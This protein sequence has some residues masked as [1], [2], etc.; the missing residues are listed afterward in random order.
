MTHSIL[1]ISNA[2][3]RLDVPLPVSEIH[4]LCCGLLCSL[5]SA[6]AKTR[7][8]TEILDAA[9]LSPEAVSGKAVELKTLDAWFSETLSS[10]NGADL[11]FSPMLP[12]DDTPASLR[13]RAL[14]E[15]CGGFTYGIGIALGQRGQKPL[16][17]DTREIIEDFQSIEAVD[18]ESDSPGAVSSMQDAKDLL[19]LDVGSTQAQTAVPSRQEDKETYYF[20]LLE[21]VRVGVLL[22]LEELRP[23]MPANQ[24]K[25]S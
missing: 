5:P 6:G 21:Y 14:G 11:D 22:V 8:F 19:A 10:L 3:E 20:E 1:S 23:V 2:L 18:M 12:D 25:P 16:P 17:K 7:W 9:S 24:N 13:L 15:F 4:G